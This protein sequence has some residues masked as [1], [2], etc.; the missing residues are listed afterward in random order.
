VPFN[1]K[2][3]GVKKW[4]VGKPITSI[5]EVQNHK[6]MYHFSSGSNGLYG[7]PEGDI[8]MLSRLVAAINK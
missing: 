5:N 2:T 3:I 4:T 6:Q 7:V 8:Y 1:N